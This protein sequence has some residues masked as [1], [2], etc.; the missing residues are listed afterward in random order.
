MGLNIWNKAKKIEVKETPTISMPT[1]SEK[2]SA[3]SATSQRRRTT[4]TQM[5]VDGGK[6]KRIVRNRQVRRVTREQFELIHLLYERG[7]RRVEISNI[8]KLSAQRVG[9][10]INHCPTWEIYEELKRKDVLAMRKKQAE[11]TARHEEEHHEEPELEQWQFI[12][13][14]S[15]ESQRIHAN[16]VRDL[17]RALGLKVEE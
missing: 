11:K 3:T 16:A 1:T 4:K 5:A 8:V 2:T 9:Y 12:V 7:L 13:G 15:N 10:I 6:K 14:W 17:A